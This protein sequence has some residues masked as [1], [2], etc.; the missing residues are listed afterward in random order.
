MSSPNARP[1]LLASDYRA[2]FESDNSVARVLDAFLVAVLCLLLAFGPLA[3]GAVQPWA[4]CVLEVG[5]ALCLVLWCV[6][7][8]VSGRLAL[9]GGALL[10]PIFLF[11][12]LV[13]LQL[14][15]GLTAYWYATWQSALLWAAYG[16]IF[17]VALQCLRRRIFVKGAALFFIGFGFVVALFA[18]VQ[19]FTWNGYL[20]WVVPNRYGGMV[21]GPYVNHSHYAGLME[22]LVPFPLVFAMTSSWQKPVRVLFGFVALVMAS[23]IFLSRSLGGMLAFAAQV[24]VLAIIVGF[25]E[26]SK[27]QV[28]L[29]FL[30]VAFLIVWLLV[31]SPGGV[32][33]RIALL[34]DPLGKAGAGNRLSIVK[35]SLRMLKARPLLGWG[36]GTFPE[37][38]PSFRSF[39]T[40]LFV[41]EAHNDYVQLAVETGLVG[42]AIA[43]SFIVL[44]YHRGL[45][46]MEQWQ[47]DIRSAAALAALIG[48]TGILVHSLSDFN[49]QIPANAALFFALAALASGSSR[50]S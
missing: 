38:Y 49:L 31:L 33:E 25:G 45:R 7:E 14:L 30:M 5:A 24:I 48:L 27:R 1:Y 44:V 10:I 26:R 15:A 4:I 46:R 17:F 11:A 40:N 28:L 9:H 39:Y 20:Y 22:M 23:T 36:L 29:M 42:F 43:C 21:Y 41:N 47:T 12:T 3:F 32:G 13:G 35:D 37:V 16:M 8:L 6:R 34:H 50:G 19:Q 18:M 2:E